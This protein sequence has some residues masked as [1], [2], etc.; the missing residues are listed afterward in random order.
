[1]VPA[2]T[3]DLIFKGREVAARVKVLR[4]DVWGGWY[5]CLSMVVSLQLT[6]NVIASKAKQSICVA[7]A[8]KHGLLRR[9]RFPQ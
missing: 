9:K 8:M 3:E 1:M 4:V 2:T 6:R 5:R 7:A